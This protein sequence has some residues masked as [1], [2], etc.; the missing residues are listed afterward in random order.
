MLASEIIF[1]ILVS[2][3]SDAMVHVTSQLQLL[4][5]RQMVDLLFAQL[6][7]LEDDREPVSQTVLTMQQ[8]KPTDKG[9]FCDE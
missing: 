9:I 2:W 4:W 6:P 1:P 3:I 7:S 8:K 5:K